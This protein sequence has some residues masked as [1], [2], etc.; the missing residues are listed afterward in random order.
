MSSMRS[1]APAVS[2]RISR[3]GSPELVLAGPSLIGLAFDSVGT[4]VVC[5]NETA[6]RL[7]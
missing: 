7:K 5:S 2:R 4:M 1:P 6:F 3:D